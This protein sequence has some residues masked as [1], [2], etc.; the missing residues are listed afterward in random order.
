LRPG[1][2]Q[3]RWL[4]GWLLGG[5]CLALAVALWILAFT[6][7]L[8]ARLLCG[9]VILALALRIRHHRFL[10]EVLPLGLTALVGAGLLVAALLGHEGRPAWT[11]AA[12]AG[13]VLAVLGAALVRESHLGPQARRWLGYLE[14]IANTALLPLA[15]WA[16]GVFAAI[17]GR[18]HGL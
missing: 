16:L 17:N 13:G 5:A 18:A 11:A 10:T 12:L 7:N 3:A 2:D 8:G 14:L 15:L 1:V 4:L 6:P 9:A